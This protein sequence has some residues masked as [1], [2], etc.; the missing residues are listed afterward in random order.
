[1]FTTFP[2]YDEGFYY[3]TI[4]LF[5]IT[6]CLVFVNNDTSTYNIVLSKDKTSGHFN[7]QRLTDKFSL[8][9]FLSV[10]HVCY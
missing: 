7:P 4:C 9:F 10:E 8:F 5:F 6:L 2:S 3:L 1:M